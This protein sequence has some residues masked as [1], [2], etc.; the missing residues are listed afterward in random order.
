MSTRPSQIDQL[1]LLIYASHRSS[2]RAGGWSLFL[3]VVSLLTFESSQSSFDKVINECDEVLTCIG[4]GPFI[5]PSQRRQK[6]INRVFPVKELPDIN[7]RG[8]QAKPIACIRIKEH[9]P[10]VKLLAEHDV[11]VCYGL[12]A[13][14]DFHGANDRVKR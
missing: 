14:S 12:L 1:G 2:R 3:I 7:T 11:W 8:V 5:T 4:R 10:V 9:S 13:I 6:V